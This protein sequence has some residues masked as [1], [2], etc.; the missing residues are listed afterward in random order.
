M[1]ISG[2]TSRTRRFFEFAVPDHVIGRIELATLEMHPIE[3]RLSPLAVLNH[4]GDVIDFE[5]IVRALPVAGVPEIMNNVV[6]VIEPKT[7][8][9]GRRSEAKRGG[10]AVTRNL[11]PHGG[12]P[13]T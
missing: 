9:A 7:G 12:A 3:E 11:T 8:Q 1:R 13:G 5:K 4:A 2:G 6:P 10:T